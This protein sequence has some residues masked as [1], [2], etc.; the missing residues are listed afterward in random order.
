MHMMQKQPHLDLW[1]RFSGTNISVSN[2][3]CVNILLM[4]LLVMLKPLLIYFILVSLKNVC[5]RPNWVNYLTTMTTG[6]VV[7]QMYCIYCMVKHSWAFQYKGILKNTCKNNKKQLKYAIQ[8]H[9]SE[10]YT[11]C[12]YTW[13][14]FPALNA[15]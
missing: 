9:M 1:N 2:H 14:D 3:L 7:L 13:G 11:W 10:L 5:S 15:N 6:I 4:A 8:L 12:I